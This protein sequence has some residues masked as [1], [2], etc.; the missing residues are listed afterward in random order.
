MRLFKIFVGAVVAATAVVAI[1][2]ASASATSVPLCTV[3]PVGL[4]DWQKSFKFS[5]DNVTATFTLEGASNCQYDMTVA[6]FSSKSV[7]LQPVK[8][9]TLYS[10]ATGRFGK[11]THTLTTKVPKCQFQLDIFTGK[12]LNVG[13][14]DKGTRYHDFANTG[15]FVNLDQWRADGNT[16]RLVDFYENKTKCAEEPKEEPKDVCPNIDGEQ[17]EIPEGHEIDGEGNCVVPE[18]PKTPEEPKGKGDDKPQVKASVQTPPSGKL[19]NTG[20]GAVAGTFFG[21][22]TIAG[23]LHAAMR[24]FF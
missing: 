22:S 12:P 19:P 4:A 1:N 23:A 8:D 17:A 18:E 3:K 9:Q 13:N 15:N 20:A 7:N 5:G 24:R 14:S 6:A 21:V 16:A 2:A 10:F 11:G